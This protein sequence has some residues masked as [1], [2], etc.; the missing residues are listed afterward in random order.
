MSSD[1]FRV[2]TATEM[3]SKNHEVVPTS[4]ITNIS[5]L[6]G[7]VPRIISDLA[8]RGLIAKV[9]NAK[10]DGYRLTY[11]GYDYLSLKALS[12]SLA[13]KS[14][15]NKIGVGKE[16]GRFFAIIPSNKSAPFNKSVTFQTSMLLRTMTTNRLC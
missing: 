16:S 5:K 8:R 15:G 10:Y 6:K 2:L 3:G 1:E 4:L 12:K 11:G 9:I 14:V 7:G 13:I